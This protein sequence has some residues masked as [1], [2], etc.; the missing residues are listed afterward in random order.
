MATDKSKVE[1][2][3]N[4]LAQE[5]ISYEADKLPQFDG[6]NPL[7][8]RIIAL[9]LQGWKFNRICDVL[10]VKYHQ[11]RRV[12]NHP[13]AQKI[14]S[15]MEKN[16]EDELQGLSSLAI[17]A[18]RDGLTCGDIKVRLDAADR[19]FKL[20][21]RYAKTD[22]AKDTAED[23]ISKLLE[24]VLEQNHTVREISRPHGQLIDVTPE[25]SNGSDPTRSSGGGKR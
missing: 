17:D 5:L 13:Q 24:V 3:V 23:V 19:V 10:D 21:G 12:F 2:D 14:L 16:L 6:L 15:E 8:Y 4:E 18:V 20:H 22:N 11:I 25:K 7:E 1:T 9:Y